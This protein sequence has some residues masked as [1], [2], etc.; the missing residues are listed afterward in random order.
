MATGVIYKG[1]NNVPFVQLSDG[2]VAHDLS[3]MTH[4]E[5]VIDGV[6][7]S[8]QAMPALFDLG[9]LAAGQIG[10]IFGSL[11]I[12]AGD[13]PIRVV[14]FDATNTTGITWIHEDDKRSLLVRV[15]RDA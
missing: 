2:K 9:Q 11:D 14:V 10:L 5:V 13:Y 7:Y 12:V 6:T 3:N 1:R 15:T 4:C 8:S